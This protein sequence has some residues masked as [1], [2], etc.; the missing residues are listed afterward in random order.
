MDY[1]EFCEDLLEREAQITA[2][3]DHRNWPP[4]LRKVLQ[5]DGTGQTDISDIWPTVAHLRDGTQIEFETAFDLGNGWVR[6]DGNGSPY[7]HVTVT[8][9]RKFSFNTWIRSFEVRVSEIQWL[10][11]A[12]S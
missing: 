11:T 7:N 2:M 4:A 3:N 1:Q 9:A 5:N 8:G 12:D 6:L 10:A